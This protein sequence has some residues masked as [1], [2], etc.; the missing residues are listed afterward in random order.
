MKMKAN[1]LMKMLTR[2]EY[3]NNTFE[4]FINNEWIYDSGKT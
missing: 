2:A 4:F 1:R 3:L